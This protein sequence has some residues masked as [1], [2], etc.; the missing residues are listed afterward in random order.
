M[1]TTSQYA[2]IAPKLAKII[3]LLASPRDQE[4][5]AALR[6]LRRAL[7][8]AGADIHQ[9]TD[10]IVASLPQPLRQSQAEKQP[11]PRPN[12]KRDYPWQEIAVWCLNVAEVLSDTESGFLRSMTYKVDA[13]T[14]RQEAWLYGLY[15][16]F[17]G[18]GWYKRPPACNPAAERKRRQDDIS[19]EVFSSVRDGLH[20]PSPDE[21]KVLAHRGWRQAVRKIKAYEAS[22]SKAALAEH[23][24]MLRE[25][26]LEDT[27][28]TM[29]WLFR[30]VPADNRRR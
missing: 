22:L 20:D 23:L 13:P 7:E 5:L 12:L 15:K 14:Y 27:R 17:G 30:N 8:I 24:A 10:I 28:A 4:A 29:L 3:P 6:A 16:R 9:F 2:E 19:F 21:I 11:P 25:D 1:N 26:G 18:H